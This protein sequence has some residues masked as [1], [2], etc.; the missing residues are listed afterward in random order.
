MNN[1]PNP[2]RKR[3]TSHSKLHHQRIPRS[4]FGLGSIASLLTVQPDTT[5][6]RVIAMQVL[7]QEVAG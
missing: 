2:T 7:L 6:L 5:C 3:G 4:R 1:N